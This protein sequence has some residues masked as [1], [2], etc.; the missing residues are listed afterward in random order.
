MCRL[1]ELQ[2]FQDIM[3]SFCNSPYERQFG[4][5]DGSNGGNCNGFRKRKIFCCERHV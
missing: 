1:E 4:T 2:V 3:E 5:N